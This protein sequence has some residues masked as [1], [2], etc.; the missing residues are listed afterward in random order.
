MPARVV[1]INLLPQSE[2]GQTFWGRFLKWAVSTGRYFLI[3]VE[4][5]VIIA[6]MSRFKLDKDLADLADN[7]AGK[8]AVL[9]AA[10][11]TEQNFRF[12]QA[13]LNA[14]ETLLN[15]QI[16]VRQILETVANYVPPQVSLTRL[17]LQLNSITLG[18]QASTTD[19]LALLLARMTTDPSWKSIDLS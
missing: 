5:V 16:G 13:R 2:F 10:Y 1:G 4:L 17:D 11:A 3:F 7:I 15:S 14:A 19:G 6:F 18:G 12:T 8:K 9:E